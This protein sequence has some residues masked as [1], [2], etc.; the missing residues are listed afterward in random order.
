VFAVIQKV[1]DFSEKHL[2]ENVKI[3]PSAIL[4]ES[5]KRVCAKALTVLQKRIL[6]YIA[7]NEHVGMTCSRHVREIS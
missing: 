3:S 2:Y 5:L 4:E 6:L 7:E 1:F